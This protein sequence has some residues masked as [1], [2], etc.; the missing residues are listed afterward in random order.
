MTRITIEE[1]KKHNETL[2][3]EQGD[4][5][6]QIEALQNYIDQV[7]EENGT[8]TEVNKLKKLLV[9][10]NDIIKSLQNQID[11]YEEETELIIENE[12]PLEMLNQIEHLVNEVKVLKGK[13]NDIITFNKRITKFDELI[14]VLEKIK[15][16]SLNEEETKEAYEK[17]NYLIDIY[18][19][20]NE[21]IKN[22]IILEVH[23]S[24]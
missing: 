18:Q 7:H 10:K 5:I 23:D 16:K 6:K 15:N 13:I 3:N 19:K 9:D 4:Y 21:K 11:T 22:K 2:E 17:L 1:L 20:N 14:K 12:T 24:Q 8:L